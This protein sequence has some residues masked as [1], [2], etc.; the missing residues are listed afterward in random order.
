MKMVLSLS[1]LLLAATPA[2][3]DA[4]RLVRQ[5]TATQLQVQGKPM[6]LLA[7]ELGNSSDTSEAY[8]A[9]HW[10]RLREMH[11]NTVL[12]PVSWELIEPKE[13]SMTGP[14]STC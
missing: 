5:G 12:A 8:M 14:A 2:L 4:P 13:A 6:L 7:G 1:A 9:P 11:L 3:A 10:K